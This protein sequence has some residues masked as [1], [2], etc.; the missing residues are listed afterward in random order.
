MNKR[1]KKRFVR[2]LTKAV[3][4]DIISKIEAGKVPDEWDGIELRELL[5]DKFKES[6][7]TDLLR[8]RGTFGDYVR[9]V[10]NNDL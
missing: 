2:E 10:F 9:T 1:E 8:S 4:D 6:A 5:A 7:R 3:A